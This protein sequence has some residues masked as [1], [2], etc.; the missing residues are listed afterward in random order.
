MRDECGQIRGT[1]M[2][3]EGSDLEPASGQVD[4]PVPLF[5]EF[6]R[7]TRSL[8]SSTATF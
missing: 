1:T 3:P 2:D 8:P 4:F 5:A 7:E 6:L